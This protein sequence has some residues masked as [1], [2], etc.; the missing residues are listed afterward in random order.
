MKL[1]FKT[2]FAK[3]YLIL[4]TIK[5]SNLSHSDMLLLVFYTFAFG[6]MLNNQ[7]KPSKIQRAETVNKLKNNILIQI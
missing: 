4:L 1:L 5:W 2:I 3:V 7:S 6:S